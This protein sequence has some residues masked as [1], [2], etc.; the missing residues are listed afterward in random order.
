[1]FR[2]I[3]ENYYQNFLEESLERQK[4]SLKDYEE[5]A[6]SHVQEM[7]LN[8][9]MNPDFQLSNKLDHPINYASYLVAYQRQID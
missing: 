9:A 1:M 4:I 6:K 8:R 3:L 5:M 2:Y 7:V